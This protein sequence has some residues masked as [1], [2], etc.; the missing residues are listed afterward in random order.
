MKVKNGLGFS[1]D[2][3]RRLL[4]GAHDIILALSKQLAKLISRTGAEMKRVW[5]Y[6]AMAVAT[7]CGKQEYGD[8]D[9]P[10]DNL[11]IVFKDRPMT[12]SFCIVCNPDLDPSEYADWAIEMGASEG[13]DNPD[14]VFPC[15]YAYPP[16]GV[17]IDSLNQCEALICDGG[18][19]YADM[20]GMGQG[21]VDL[22]TVL[23]N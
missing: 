5:L 12:H 3:A 23:D 14:D 16:E 11:E 4:H 6:G 22:S 20:V 18:A 7:A 10:R 8:C 2:L 19:E 17:E 21:N 13:P 15:L 9:A 1:S